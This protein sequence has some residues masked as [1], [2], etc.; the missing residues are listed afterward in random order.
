MRSLVTATACLLSLFV[1]S[2]PV[3]AQQRSVVNP[4]DLRQ[5]VLDQVQ[6]HEDTR[7]TL[8]TV[9]KHSQV[10]VVAERLGLDVTRADGAIATMTAA[11]LERAAGPAR[12]LDT[13]LAGG[14]NTIVISTTT[15]L[16]ILIIILLVT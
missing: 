16:L 14:A 13:R 5:A 10:R 8:R 9:L 4:A 6:T 7:E 1:L 2:A 15:L 12:D 3:L 11:D